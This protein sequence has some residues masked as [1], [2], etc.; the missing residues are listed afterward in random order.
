MFDMGTAVFT[1]LFQ[2]EATVICILSGPMTKEE[3]L[4]VTILFFC[5]EA[6]I[7]LRQ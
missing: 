4:I 5:S 2:C 6:I 3:T 1:F 7:K